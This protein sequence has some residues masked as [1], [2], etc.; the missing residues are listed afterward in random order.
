MSGDVCVCEIFT[1]NNV[2]SIFEIFLP[3]K[4]YENKLN[5]KFYCLGLLKIIY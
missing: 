2:D 1:K 4:K 5:A 3:T